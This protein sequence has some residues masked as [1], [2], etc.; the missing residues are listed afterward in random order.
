MHTV[1]L[2]LFTRP[3]RDSWMLKEKGISYDYFFLLQR[4][5]LRINHMLII[6]VNSE[7]YDNMFYNNNPKTCMCTWMPE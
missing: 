1:N 7:A 5:T 6:I 3:C 2:V 4:I